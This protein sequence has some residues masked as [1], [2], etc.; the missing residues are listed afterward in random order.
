MK[1]TDYKLQ[2]AHEHLKRWWTVTKVLVKSQATVF[3]S[4]W[5]K[6]MNINFIIN[7]N[8]NVMFYCYLINAS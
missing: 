8:Y 5:E 2:T 3:L 4:F 6:D 1:I 7:I